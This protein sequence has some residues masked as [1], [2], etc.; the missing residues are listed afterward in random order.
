MTRELKA[1]VEDSDRGSENDE[2]IMELTQQVNTGFDSV[3]TVLN[4]ENTTNADEHKPSETLSTNKDNHQVPVS[5]LVWK[6]KPEFE[7]KLGIAVSSKQLSEDSSI[8]A[9][10][11]K[12]TF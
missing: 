11:T 10:P 6:K 12:I 9:P 8:G 5:D 2:R 3:R 7:E 4:T 1:K